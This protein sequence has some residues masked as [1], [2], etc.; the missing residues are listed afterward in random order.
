MYNLKFSIGTSNIYRYIKS[1]S[2]FRGEKLC[3]I[4]HRSSSSAV[5]FLEPVWPIILPRQA[6][7][8]LFW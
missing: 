3:E 7:L 6:V 4:K 5:A 2:E 8:T 1:R